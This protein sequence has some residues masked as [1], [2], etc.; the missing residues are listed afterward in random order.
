MKLF[1]YLVVILFIAIA[2]S[3]CA[4]MPGPYI[5]TN[6]ISKMTTQE[7][8]QYADEHREG[9]APMFKVWEETGCKPMSAYDAFNQGRLIIHLG[10]QA[11]VT[12]KCAAL[13][14][15]SNF[16]QCAV[17]LLAMA[18]PMA[19]MKGVVVGDCKQSSEIWATEGWGKSM[20]LHEIRHVQGYADQLY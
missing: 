10:N 6:G 19:C 14:C 3:A 8:L 9:G 18:P 15:E 16:T 7:L 13:I 17:M 4:P 11:E 20:L 5:S 1:N 2:L 12:G